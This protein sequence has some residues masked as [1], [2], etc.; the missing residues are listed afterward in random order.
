MLNDH[1]RFR[2][3]L[4]LRFH[5]FLLQKEDSAVLIDADTGFEVL[6]IRCVTHMN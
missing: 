3:E 5:L 1:N 4:R 6:G 2:D